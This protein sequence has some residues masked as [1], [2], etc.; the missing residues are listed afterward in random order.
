MHLPSGGRCSGNMGQPAIG[1][2]WG[3]ASAMWCA[4]GQ[5]KTERRPISTAESVFFGSGSF[6]S[7][8]R[9]AGLKCVSL[10]RFAL[11]RVTNHPWNWSSWWRMDSRAGRKQPEKDSAHH[12]KARGWGHDSASGTCCCSATAEP[13]RPISRRPWA[14]PLASV[15]SAYG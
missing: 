12:P 8:N 10:R 3:G 14:W 15:A 11:S 13:E 2:F 6:L 9:R 5:H 4:D 7:Q 1:I